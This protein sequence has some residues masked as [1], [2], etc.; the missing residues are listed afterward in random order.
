LTVFNA[1]SPGTLTL[2]SARRIRD[3]CHPP[4]LLCFPT[5]Q[6]RRLSAHRFPA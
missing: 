1:S 2:I 3:F 5:G 4:V 6:N